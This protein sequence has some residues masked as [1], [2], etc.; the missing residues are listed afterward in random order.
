MKY[1]FLKIIK[2]YKRVFAK[3]LNTNCPYFPTCSIYAMQALEEWGAICGGGMSLYR[4]IRC[5][6]F[7]KG[8]FDPIK[9]KKSNVKWL[10]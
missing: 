5:N 1:L 4:V 7:T 8:G 10:L 2:F 6:P 3:P 9:R